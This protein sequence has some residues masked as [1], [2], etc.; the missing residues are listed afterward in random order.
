MHRQFSTPGIKY[1]TV[2]SKL[3]Q[4]LQPGQLKL[5]P[6]AHAYPCAWA[7]MR[8]AGSS[9][10]VGN[11]GLTESVP[12]LGTD[13]F[14]DRH[15]TSPSCLLR[16]AL[17][18]VIYICNFTCIGAYTGRL[19]DGLVYWKHS[20]VSYCPPCHAHPCVYGELEPSISLI[21]T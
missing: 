18:Y 8:S 1:Q 13:A 3:W 9:N 19:L 16:A 15:V 4:V 11:N 6:I 5:L 7:L 12:L 20:C 2:I 17:M 14:H 21:L 10:G